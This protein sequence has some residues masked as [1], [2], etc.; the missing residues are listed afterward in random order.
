LRDLCR[1]RRAVDLD[2]LTGA[3]HG[4]IDRVGRDH[5]DLALHERGTPRRESE[6]T[7]H[8]IVP[9]AQLRLVRL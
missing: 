5:V 1:R 4:T 3:I 8:R 2:L 7:Q 9:L 6:V